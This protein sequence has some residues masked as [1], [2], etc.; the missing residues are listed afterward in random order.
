M[1][2]PLATRGKELFNH[3]NLPLIFFLLIYKNRAKLKSFCKK[4]V[5]RGGIEPPSFSYD[6]NRLKFCCTFPYQ[7]T[8]VCLNPTTRRPRNIIPHCRWRI[9]HA[10]LPISGNYELDN[11]LVASARFIMYTHLGAGGRIWT[12]DPRVTSQ[13]TTAVHFRDGK[14]KIRCSTW[15]SYTGIVGERGIEPLITAPKA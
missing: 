2:A 4:F 7:K 1:S 15:L 12:Y 11:G 6:E 8:F 10:T 13:K 9:S 3:L 14:L 5:A